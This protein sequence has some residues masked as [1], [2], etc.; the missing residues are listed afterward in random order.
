MAVS[1]KSDHSAPKQNPARGRVCSILL[2]AQIKLL[3]YTTISSPTLLLP[4]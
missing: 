3:S 1:A 2:S 4:A